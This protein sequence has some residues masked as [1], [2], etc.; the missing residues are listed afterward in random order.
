MFRIEV[1]GAYALYTRPECKTERASYPVPTPSAMEGLLRSVFWKPAIRYVIDKIVVYRPVRYVCV[2]RNE[3]K[4]KVKP[5]LIRRR[6]RGEGDPCI[7]AREAV[8]ISQRASVLLKDVR[9]GVEFHFEMTGI[10]SDGEHET[11]AKYAEMLR[12]R[13]EKGQY[14]Q[15]PFLGCREFP[16]ERLRLVGAFTPADVD[17][18]LRGEHDLGVMLYGLVYRDDPA[19]KAA[20]K[21]ESFSDEADAVYYHPR[22]RD[23]VIDVQ[24][25]REAGR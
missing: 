10:R 23:G 18:S 4:E 17:E 15:K 7:Y 1:E 16:A 2:R 11:A 21:R 8:T 19:G 22:M 3:V 14:F 25:W 13:L 24:K 6:M 12:R 5:A 9:Y 20:W